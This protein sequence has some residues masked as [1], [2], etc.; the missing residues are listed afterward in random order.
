MSRAV[1]P[2]TA[3]V[4]VARLPP[5]ARVG[6]DDGSARRVPSRAAYDWPPRTPLAGTGR[7]SAASGTP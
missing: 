1:Q 5:D 2:A 4:K 7:E 3:G 6:P